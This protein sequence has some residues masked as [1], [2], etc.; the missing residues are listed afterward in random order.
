MKHGQQNLS[1]IAFYPVEFIV[2]KYGIRNFEEVGLLV[3]ICCFSR[4]EQFKTLLGRCI[5]L[6]IGAKFRVKSDRNKE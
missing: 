4:V 5:E 2:W 1:R 3:V 6:S